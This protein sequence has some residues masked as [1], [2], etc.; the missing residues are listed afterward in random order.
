[1]V[2]P[3]MTKQFEYQ[4]TDN[5]EITALVEEAHLQG[6]KEVTHLFLDH[7][8]DPNIVRGRREPLLHQDNSDIPEIRRRDGG[9]TWY[10]DNTRCYMMA[11][12]NDNN[13]NTKE[14]MDA[15]G[16]LIEEELKKIGYDAEMKGA[17]IYDANTDEQLVGLSES[18]TR[19]STVM[20]ACW[21]EED[22]EKKA[23]EDLEKLLEEDETDKNIFYNSIKSAEGLYD[24]LKTE[25]GP[26]RVYEQFISQEAT[27]A[28]KK[29]DQRE[30]GIM[31]GVC[32]ID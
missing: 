13:K 4:V 15:W 22:L 10:H 9:L 30:Y 27:E 11:V 21:Y 14:C 32:P 5:E 8:E 25:I 23:N 1:M 19:N 28:V 7:Q 3:A 12:P 17:D 18:S 2:V 24:H 26:E 31:R 20:R 16:S 29:Y 6:Q